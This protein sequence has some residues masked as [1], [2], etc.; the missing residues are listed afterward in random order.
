V[1]TF[2]ESPEGQGRV[3]EGRV[4]CVGAI[5]E[6]QTGRVRFLGASRPDTGNVN[7]MSGSVTQIAT[8]VDRIDQI[9]TGTSK[10]FFHPSG[11][12]LMN[13]LGIGIGLATSA[14]NE[15]ATR[16]PLKKRVNLKTAKALG[17]TNRRPYPTCR[18]PS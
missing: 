18:R 13:I 12:S 8:R 15:G 14:A 6:I 4:K 5:Y 17:L 2:I 7:Q 9:T 10:Q 16:G 3:A 11:R 1:R